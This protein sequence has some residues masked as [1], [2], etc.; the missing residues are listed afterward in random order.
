MSTSA[1][2]PATMTT[3]TGGTVYGLAG[4]R[5]DRGRGR[6]AREGEK[7]HDL[8]R[9]VMRMRRTRLHVPAIMKLVFSTD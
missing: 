9:R 1:P 2:Q 7:G 5:R 3:P 4:F 6:K 8:Q